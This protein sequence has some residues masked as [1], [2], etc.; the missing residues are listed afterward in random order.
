M[1]RAIE[2]SPDDLQQIEKRY[3]RD[4]GAGAHYLEKLEQMTGR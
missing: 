3:R 4:Q 1:D 2:L